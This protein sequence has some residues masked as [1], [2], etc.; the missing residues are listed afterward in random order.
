MNT[1]EQKKY[2]TRLKEIEDGVVTFTEETVKLIDE[3]KER[4]NA[5]EESIKRLEKHLDEAQ[6]H[7]LKMEKEQRNYVD[8]GDK[9]TDLRLAGFLC[10]GF[11]SRLNWLLTGR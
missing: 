3:I 10:R 1:T 4:M 2:T 8:R 11:W 6:T 5:I 7:S 9:L